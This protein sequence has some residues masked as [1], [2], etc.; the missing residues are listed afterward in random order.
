MG[1]CGEEW[2]IGLQ[3]GD[4]E[5]HNFNAVSGLSS[6]NLADFLP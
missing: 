5:S 4:I 3:D 6:H 1:A 2:A